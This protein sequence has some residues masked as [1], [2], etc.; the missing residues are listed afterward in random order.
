[1]EKKVI[2]DVELMKLRGYG[3]C[4]YLSCLLSMD[5]DESSHEKLKLFCANAIL[6]SDLQDDSFSEYKSNS[7]VDYAGRVNNLGFNWG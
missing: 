5:R 6:N 7:K 3:N 4:L 1:M 2:N